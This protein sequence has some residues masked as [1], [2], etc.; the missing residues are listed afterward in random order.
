MRKF[1]IIRLSS[2]GDIVLTSPVVRCLRNRYPDAEIHFC[3][4]SQYA[5]I[6]MHNPYLSK[7]HLYNGNLRELISNL[8]AERFDFVVDLHKNIRSYI[9]RCRLGVPSATFRK[10]NFRKWLLVRTR[11]N[12]MP[13]IHIVDRYFAAVHKL[14]VAYDGN[15]LDFFIHAKSDEV[16]SKLPQ[17]YKSGFI[18]VVIG[19]RHK[20]K[21]LPAE[22]LIT[23][24]RLLSMPVVLV[25][26]SEDYNTGCE[27]TSAVGEKVFNACGSFS[28][29]ESALV[30]KHA[31]AVITHDTGLMHIAAALKLPVVSVWGNTVPE[32]GMTPFYP[33]NSHG[34]FAIFQVTGLNC[35][36]CSKLGFNKCPEKHFNCM[37]LQSEMAIAQSANQ[38][39]ISGI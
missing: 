34:L 23:I 3:T 28:L 35:R 39:A 31:K 17:T 9:I 29:H 12:L 27:I 32:F 14:G 10:L 33:H 2:I 15:G 18:A 26:G 24:C 7:V 1:L 30:L 4:K 22:K 13:E 21:M 19:G 38:F 25:G 11:I 37:H 6:V 36:P 16:F 20:T 8:K 5:G